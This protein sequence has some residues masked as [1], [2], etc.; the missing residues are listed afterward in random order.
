MSKPLHAQQQL[1]A[2]TPPL[3]LEYPTVHI[4]TCQNITNVTKQFW[5]P[6]FQERMCTLAGEQ[7]VF[8]S[9]GSPIVIQEFDR[10]N[11]ESPLELCL[12]LMDELDNTICCMKWV[13]V[14]DW[15]LSKD[16]AKV[17][18]EP[19]SG[20]GNP[21]KISKSW[22][23]QVEKHPIEFHHLANMLLQQIPQMQ[24]A[25]G[26]PIP[27]SIRTYPQLIW[28]IYLSQMKVLWTHM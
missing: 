26:Y 13:I 21:A 10:N 5:S 20:F 23:W 12:C 15:Q 3:H 25:H 28:K 2:A 8:F 19:L 22:P 18:F 14:C 1:D 16:T 7:T 27:V 17:I 11:S 6:V 4:F 24:P 9:S